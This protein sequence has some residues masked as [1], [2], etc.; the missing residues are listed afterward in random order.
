M[1][2]QMTFPPG[3]V[4]R[5]V[6]EILGASLVQRLPRVTMLLTVYAVM[7]AMWW[8][9]RFDPDWARF[10]VHETGRT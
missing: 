5:T 4:L 6:A 10:A 7:G 2:K 8:F 1:F 3:C 9:E